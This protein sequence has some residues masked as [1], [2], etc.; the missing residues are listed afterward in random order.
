LII[1][2]TLSHRR[3]GHKTF[4]AGFAEVIAALGTG[5]SVILSSLMIGIDQRIIAEDRQAFGE[6]VDGALLRG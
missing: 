3:F 1:R 2:K 5:V 4:G 6:L